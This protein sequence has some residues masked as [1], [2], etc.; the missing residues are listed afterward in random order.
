MP[1]WSARRRSTTIG[2][3]PSIPAHL[4]VP[5]LALAAAGEMT[6]RSPAPTLRA[7]LAAADRPPRWGDDAA[8][9][10]GAAVGTLAGILEESLPGEAIDGDTRLRWLGVNE[11]MI[12]SAATNVV[13]GG[14]R[15]AYELVARLVVG[16]AEALAAC[17]TDGRQFAAG[18]RARYP[19]HV[20][21]R[22]ELDGLCVN[23]PS[24]GRL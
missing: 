6:I 15:H 13:G 2:Q 4:L 22:G 11:E 14:R 20:A 17:G 1:P 16:H 3:T 7:G 21:F 10:L 19:R 9:E 23:S 18:F 8:G 24:I 12:V 5:Y